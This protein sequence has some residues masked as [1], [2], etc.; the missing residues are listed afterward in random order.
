LDI[1]GYQMGDYSYKAKLRKGTSLF[2][3]TR[4]QQKKH[5]DFIIFEVKW[6]QR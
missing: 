6:Q 1:T 3:L 5:F 4:V 2:S